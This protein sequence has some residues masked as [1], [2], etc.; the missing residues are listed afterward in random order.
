M[1]LE[2][3]E[4][5]AVFKADNVVGLDRNP[6][7]YSR[8]ERLRR[9]RRRGAQSR[10]TPHV[11]FDQAREIGHGDAIILDMG[12]DN[13]GSE[14]DKGVFCFDDV[15]HAIYPCY[16]GPPIWRTSGHKAAWE[17]RFST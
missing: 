15:R 6:D 9:R 12:G 17:Y 13:V 1:A 8:D 3:L 7:R 16:A 11:R 5:L 14:R 2:H 10:P 4:L